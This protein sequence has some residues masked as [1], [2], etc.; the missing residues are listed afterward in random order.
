MNSLTHEC[1]YYN[2]NLIECLFRELYIYHYIA[3][4]N[5]NNI[6]DFTIECININIIIV[7]TDF[8]KYFKLYEYN[9]KKQENIKINDGAHKYIYVIQKKNNKNNL[10]F[11]SL[12]Q[13]IKIINNGGIYIRGI[14]NNITINNTGVSVKMC[15]PPFRNGNTVSECS[16]ALLVRNDSKTVF[17]SPVTQIINSIPDNKID[18]IFRNEEE[19][20]LYNMDLVLFNNLSEKYKADEYFT[21]F[22][23]FLISYK[24][25]LGCDLLMI[26][27]NDWSNTA[28]RFMKSLELQKINV[29]LLKINKH[30]FNYPHQGIIINT[31]S[32]L[33]KK[34]PVIVEIPEIQPI[35]DIAKDINNIWFHASSIFMH[36]NQ[37]INKLLKNKSYIVAHGGTTYRQFPN[38]VNE[39][40]NMIVKKTLIQCPDLLDLGAKNEKLIYYPVNVNI[41]KCNIIKTHNKLVFGHFPSSSID[42]G[43]ALILKVLKPFI[44]SGKILYIGPKTAT[45]GETWELW[46]EHIKRY[47]ECD[48][49]I[50]TINL[51]QN[52]KPFGEWGNTCLEAAASGCIV[53]T[54]FLQYKKYEKEYNNTP[55]ILITN[56]ETDLINNINMLLKLTDD[57]IYNMKHKFRKWVEDYHSL[58]KCGIRLKEF[59]FD[60]NI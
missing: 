23:K 27:N 7:V 1:S 40:F 4:Y 44:D 5:D 48:V 55:P 36:K 30:C 31:S 43:T 26:A 3:L 10:Q 46:E 42:K 56:N 41:I 39:L 49:Y 29:I 8:N 18:Y 54:N 17:E 53:M 19:K 58:E 11:I 60:I 57:E 9:I 13:V 47:Q 59:I 15:D 52:G 35:L 50:E 33:I 32:K 28:Y 51:T 34:N 25:S 2:F 38:K 6:I 20:I 21:L 16:G 45:K 14:N 22:D 24:L 37:T 12:P